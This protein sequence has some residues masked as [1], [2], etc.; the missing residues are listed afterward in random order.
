[1]ILNSPLVVRITC[2]PL[3]GA[4]V[5]AQPCPFNMAKALAAFIRLRENTLLVV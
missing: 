2:I 1:V 3:L 5:A 4:I